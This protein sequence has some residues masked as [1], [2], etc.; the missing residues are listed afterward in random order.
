MSEG[1]RTGMGETLED[2]LGDEERRLLLGLADA[3]ADVARLE[4]ET[5][6][7]RERV[8]AAQDALARFYEGDRAAVS[9]EPTIEVWLTGV[10]GNLLQESGEFDG[11]AR[12]A[13][14]RMYIRGQG[15]GTRAKLIAKAPDA[16]RIATWLDEKAFEIRHSDAHKGLSG[17]EADAVSRKARNDSNSVARSAAVIREEVNRAR[18][19][20]S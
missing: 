14:D 11:G 13:I 10:S 9:V 8:R 1:V 16:L 20:S 17:D 7:A 18:G 15:F 12:E 4:I 2:R 3:R 19:L 6:Q 5:M